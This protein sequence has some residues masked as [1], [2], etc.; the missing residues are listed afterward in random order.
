MKAADWD[1]N[2]GS[3]DLITLSNEER[4]YFCLEPLEP[5]WEVKVFY[6]KTNYHYKRTKIFFEGERIV[7]TI[8]EVKKIISGDKKV[9]E[10]YIESDTCLKTENREWLVP[11]TARGKK[12]K[13]TPASV[14]NI[15]PFGCTLTF[16]INYDEPSGLWVSNFRSNQELAIGE[17]ERI[18]RIRSNT[19]FRDFLNYYIATCPPGYFDEVQRVKN[20]VHQTV[21]YR[22]GD[23]FRVGYDRTRYYYGL[24]LGEVRKINKW[25]EL[26]NKHSLRSL[27]SVPLLI[28]F[29]DAVLPQDNLSAQELE[30]I[31]M[32][33]LEIC[34]DSDI[35]WGTHPIIGHKKIRPEDIYF[36]LVCTKI[37]SEDPHNTLFTQDMFIGHGLMKRPEQY[38]LYIEWGFAQTELG[39]EQLSEQ[40]RAFFAQ[41][42]SPHGGVRVG[43]IS[44][45]IDRTNEQR[46]KLRDFRNNLLIPENREIRN[47]LFA[48]LGLKPDADFDDFAKKYNGLTR[49]EIAIRL[50]KD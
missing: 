6:S 27:M 48:C 45:F 40:L 37:I 21:K 35:I 44:I 20:S 31:P 41:Y 46:L 2:F 5:A 1:K 30:Q 11:L 28:R 3:D 38:K 39:S 33:P 29:Y 17:R 42:S 19:E 49:D 26:P 50:N 25:K 34:C 32:C 10:R 8:V 15:L 7:K 47:E 18:G 43:T 23:I 16:T 13:V 9:F 22:A 36:H 12:K 4:K 14:D 24:I